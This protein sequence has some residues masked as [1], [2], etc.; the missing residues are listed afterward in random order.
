M[1]AKKNKKKKK[2]LRIFIVVI[3]LVAIVGGFLYF[4]GASQSVDMTPMVLVTHAT[5]GDL[6]EQIS[7][8]GNVFGVDTITVYAPASGTV[9]SVDIREGD[10]IKIGDPIVDYDLAKLEESLYQAKLQNEKSQIA[11]DEAI[12]SSSRGNGKVKEANVN[13]PVLEQQIEDHTNYLNNLSKALQD[14]Q[15]KSSNDTVLANYNLKKQQADLT[16]KLAT[17]TPGTTDYNNTAKALESVNTQ[18]E[19]LALSQSLLQ[20]SAYEEDLE[21]KISQEQETLAELKEYQAKMQA[22]KTSGEASVMDDSNRRQLDIDKELTDLAYKKQLDEAELARAGISS[23]VQGVVRSV[24]VTPGTQIAAGMAVAVI[25]RTDKLIVKASANK[26]AMERLKVGQKAEVTIG[27]RTYE[28]VV[29]HIDRIATISNNNATVGFEVEISG[30]DELIYIGM[31]AKMTID[32][33]FAANTLQLP[34]H[35]VNADKDGDFVYLVQNGV[36]SK[37]YVKVGIVSHGIVQI[38][39]GITE[40]EEVVAKYDGNLEEGMTVNVSSAE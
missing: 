22:Q 3:V 8:S 2:G 14:Y 36:I 13:L 12:S 19:Q 6:Q 7:S 34:A 30:V 38:T 4:K 29:S 11:Y 27:E 23:Q 1:K 16:A 10:E 20:K 33:N 5:R 17:Q 9:L 26:Y 37:K 24:N 15:T 25:E 28:G 21:K 35:A 32:T 40:S 39:D 18:L 31:E